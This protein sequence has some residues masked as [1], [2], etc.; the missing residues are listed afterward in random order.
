MGL[1]D[2]TPSS[3][4]ARRADAVAAA[5]DDAEQFADGSAQLAS[6]YQELLREV[7]TLGARFAFDRDG[8]PGAIDAVRAALP[9]MECDLFDAV[10]DDYA[11]EI[12]AIEESLYQVVRAYGRRLKPDRS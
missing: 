7:R 3:V 6:T 9:A 10:L 8:R 11:C 12:A 5:I 4:V 1:T 2:G